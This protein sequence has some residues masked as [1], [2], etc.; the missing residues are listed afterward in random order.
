MWNLVTHEDRALEPVVAWHAE[1]DRGYAVVK[2]CTWDRPRLFSR[3][4]GA[5]AAARLNILGARIFSRPDG[6]VFDTLFVN[7]PET[8]K[9]PGREA[10]ERFEELLAR[11]LRGEEVDFESLTKRTKAGA[12]IYRPAAFEAIPTTIRFDNDLMRG[13]TVIE[14]Q[15]EDH[16]GLLY[17]I[18]RTLGDLRLEVEF[19]RIGTEKGVAVDTFHVRESGRGTVLP[20]ERW[21]EVEKRLRTTLETKG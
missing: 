2:V 15:A 16:L 14:I 19:A 4:A 21:D 7:D 12:P 9:P 13:Q 3:I 18:T 5:L 8:G 6:P 1:P 20:R 11:S 17:D 10:R